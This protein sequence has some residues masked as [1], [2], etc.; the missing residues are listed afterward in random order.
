MS[1]RMASSNV[2][3]TSCAAIE[4]SCSENMVM[5]RRLRGRDTGVPL[6][7]AS[8]C[9]EAGELQRAGP[10]EGGRMR[11]EG[12]QS[13]DDVGACTTSMDA[14]DLRQAC[15]AVATVAS[16]SGCASITFISTIII[17]WRLSGRSMSARSELDM[18]TFFLAGRMLPNVRSNSSLSAAVVWKK[19]RRSCWGV[20]RRATM[21][22]RS[23]TAA[24]SS[25]AAFSSMWHVSLDS[26]LFSA[27]CQLRRLS[28]ELLERWRAAIGSCTEVN[29]S[30]A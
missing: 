16:A 20:A 28:L 18:G 25:T 21:R 6:P 27:A 26:T 17:W 22:S 19:L 9:R 5:A 30:T 4:L 7:S 15:T 24:P 12:R 3:G 23:G 29:I 1:I 11:S 14:A 2:S 8:A 10:P 13:P